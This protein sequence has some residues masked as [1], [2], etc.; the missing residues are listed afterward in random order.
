ML[1]D[2]GNAQADV[3]AGQVADAQAAMAELASEWA[4]LV[5]AMEVL[6]GVSVQAATDPV[7]I[8]QS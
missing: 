7:P 5:A 1:A 8:A 2:L 3:S 4:A 6:V